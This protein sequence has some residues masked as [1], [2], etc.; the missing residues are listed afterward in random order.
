MSKALSAVL[1]L[2]LLTM[3]A[4]SRDLG[5]WENA[6]PAVRAWYRSLMQPDNPS[7]SCCDVSDAYYVDI[8]V[9]D[10]LTVAVIAD[11]RP[12]GPLG[13]AHIPVGTEF[14]VPNH[15]LKFDRGNPTGRDIL[16]VGVT[17]AVFCLVQGSGI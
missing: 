12:D 8:K 10:G 7:V 11:D 3:P 4:H 14:V 2:A 5:Q 9:R 13:R 6:D 1:M 15:K 17:G 16:F